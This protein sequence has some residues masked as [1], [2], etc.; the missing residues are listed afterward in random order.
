MW[1]TIG[2]NMDK[3]ELIQ[4]IEEIKG[5]LPKIT[6]LFTKT[7]RCIEIAEYCTKDGFPPLIASFAEEIGDGRIYGEF[8]SSIEQVNDVF[9]FAIASRPE[10]WRFCINRNDPDSEYEVFVRLKIKEEYLA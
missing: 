10:K 2:E 9:E 3:A 8:I 5:K 4:K 7:P 1:A 6:S